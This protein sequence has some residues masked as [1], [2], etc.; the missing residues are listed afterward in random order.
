MTAKLSPHKQ[1]KVTRQLASMRCATASCRAYR[2]LPWEDADEYRT[3][4]AALTT[5][6]A[7]KGRR[8]SISSRNW[9]V[10]SGESGAFT[11]PRLPPTGA[12]WRRRSHP[13]AR[14]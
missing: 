3:L 14:P 2:V 4:V 13:T 6:H 12:G 5:E 10:S 1:S 9:P 7:P 8:R 11:W